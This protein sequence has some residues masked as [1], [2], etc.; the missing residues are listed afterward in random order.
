MLHLGGQQRLDARAD[1]ERRLGREAQHLE[2]GAVGGLGDAREIDPRGDV[3]QAHVDEWIVVRAMPEVAAQRAACALGM[4]ELRARQ[5][6]VD[7]QRDAFL[8]L[9]RET[10]D[11]RLERQA[12]LGHIALGQWRGQRFDD[13]RDGMHE[14]GRRRSLAP[15]ESVAFERRRRARARRCLRACARSTKRSTGMASSTSLASTTPRIGAFRP[16]V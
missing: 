3:L 10:R 13:V 11:P 2:P 9:R 8:E 5:A 6:V 16:V 15:V 14:L 4:I 12:D 1:Q 7:Q